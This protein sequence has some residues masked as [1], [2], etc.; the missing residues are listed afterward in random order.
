MDKF[1]GIPNPFSI[2]DPVAPFKTNKPCDNQLRLS[3]RVIHD[4]VDTKNIKRTPGLK[5][6]GRVETQRQVPHEFGNTN[7]GFEQ[8]E[9]VG[10]IRKD[11]TKISNIGRLFTN[12]T[13]SEFENENLKN[14]KAREHSPQDIPRRSNIGYKDIRTRDNSS[15]RDTVYSI[16][17][18]NRNWFGNRDLGK[19]VLGW[20]P[21]RS[22][23][24]RLS[25]RN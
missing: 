22:E 21:K 17:S 15:D 25:N 2:S 14:K 3:S 6:T 20:N 23:R 18:P 13:A 19:M 5:K 8:K 11:P 24:E 4:T 16:K 10:T 1:F 7:L 12:T 9:N